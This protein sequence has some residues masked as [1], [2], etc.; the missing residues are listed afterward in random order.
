M[1]YEEIGDFNEAWLSEPWRRVGLGK[2]E[3]MLFL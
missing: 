3:V 1:C 2:A